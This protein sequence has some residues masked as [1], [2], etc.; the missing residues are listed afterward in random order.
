MKPRIIFHDNKFQ[1]IPEGVEML[2]KPKRPLSPASDQEWDEYT[3]L[4]IQYTHDFH[5]QF[6]PIH[7][8][9]QE[10]VEIHIKLFYEYLNPLDPSS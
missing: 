2:D 3:A 9:D 4:S 10:K 7:E 8:E 6:I 5:S 1:V